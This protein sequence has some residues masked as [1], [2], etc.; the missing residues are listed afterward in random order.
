MTLEQIKNEITASLKEVRESSRDFSNCESYDDLQ[1]LFKKAIGRIALSESAE[2]L[3]AVGDLL[4]AIEELYNDCNSELLGQPSNIELFSFDFELYSD[5]EDT[6]Y[7]D[8]SDTCDDESFEADESFEEYEEN[9]INPKRKQKKENSDLIKK[10]GK[11]I[12]ANLFAAKAAFDQK[13]T[14]ERLKKPN[15][16]RICVGFVALLSG[17]FSGITFAIRDKIWWPW[18]WFVWAMIGFGVSYLILGTVYS[19]VISKKSKKAVRSMAVARFVL[20]PIMIAASL[21][22]GL[23]FPDE[24]TVG[25]AYLATLPFTVFGILTYIIYRI[26]L[27][28]ALKSS[29]STTKNT[30]NK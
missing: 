22:L 25:G 18:E 8:N 24:L 27:E 2:D 20:S 12:K 9:E 23:S 21:I 5:A 28:F 14:S 10:D 19:I 29:N 13:Y 3:E 15:F 4:M 7:R 17:I 26:R 30:K 11:K 6:D 16:M 1:S